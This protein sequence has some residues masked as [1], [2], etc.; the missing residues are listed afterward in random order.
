MIDI[1]SIREWVAAN[2]F[3][4]ELN[5]NRRVEITQESFAETILDY[6]EHEL[7]ADMA[8]AE[9]VRAW[10]DGEPVPVPLGFDDFDVSSRLFEE[11]IDHAAHYFLNGPDSA[12]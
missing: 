4:G 1:T 5:A 2:V 9:R 6:I 8:V 11:G 12:T 3:D 7:A 10:D